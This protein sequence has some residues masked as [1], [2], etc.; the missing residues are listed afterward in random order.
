MN[1]IEILHAMVRPL[2]VI[3]HTFDFGAWNLFS[4]TAPMACN[5]ESIDAAS[6]LD[7]LY[8]RLMREAPQSIYGFEPPKDWLAEA[9]KSANALSTL[10][11]DG[12]QMFAS[13]PE[14]LSFEYDAPRSPQAIHDAFVGRKPSAEGVE[15]V[16]ATVE[17]LGFNVGLMESE[18]VRD[19]RQEAIDAA[20]WAL[21]ELSTRIPTDRVVALYKTFEG[22]S[23]DQPHDLPRPLPDTGMSTQD[24]LAYLTRQNSPDFDPAEAVASNILTSE[25]LAIAYL[26]GQIERKPALETAISGLLFERKTDAVMLASA[27]FEPNLDRIKSRSKTVLRAKHVVW[28]GIQAAS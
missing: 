6:N 23:N 28:P 10:F 11:F 3:K 5:Q 13:D 4:F 12:H 7:P 27:G 2:P 14:F 17:A 20:P 9:H 8:Q 18:E 25:C 19:Y 26:L 15:K 21:T 22:K 1:I 24:A 16:N